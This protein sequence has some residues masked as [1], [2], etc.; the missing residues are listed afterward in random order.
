MFVTGLAYCG[1]SNNAAI[2]KLL[3][4]AV[5]GAPPCSPCSMLFHYVCCLYRLYFC[6]MHDAAGSLRFAALLR[7]AVTQSHT[8][9]SCVTAQDLLPRRRA[10]QHRVASLDTFYLLP[11]CLQMCLTMCAEPRS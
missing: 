2:Q 3:H 7:S 11:F 4:F 6:S 9:G 5:S 10:P 1:T 8:E